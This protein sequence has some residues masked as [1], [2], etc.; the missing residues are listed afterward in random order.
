MFVAS[1]YISISDI[2]M[3]TFKFLSMLGVLVLSF[4]LAWSAVVVVALRT[5][6]EHRIVNVRKIP[7]VDKKWENFSSAFVS[8]V[9]KVAA[10]EQKP[11]VMFAGSSVTYGYPWQERI[12]YTKVVANDLPEWKVSN[13]S[14][15]G[16]GMQSLTDFATCAL[17]SENRPSILIV[18]IPLVNSTASISPGSVRV[19]RRCLPYD[20]GFPGYWSLV[21]SKPYG[22]G[23]VSILWDEEAYEKPDAD[24]VITPLPPTYFA[25][26]Q[27]FQK[28][29]DYYVSELRRFISSVSVM[30]GKVFVYV[31]PILA[32]AISKAGGDRAAVEY[33]IELTNK[34]CLEY[35]NVTCLDSSI[36]SDRP[37]LFYNLTHLNHRGHRALAQWFE[38]YI[39]SQGGSVVP[40]RR[41][42][43]TN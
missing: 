25:D 8:E 14:I 28:I 30:S 37:E 27:H 1:S 31:S 40:P 6:Y 32:T 38:P 22:L 41:P 39:V 20:Q 29:E 10:T 7:N 43:L 4:H 23:W 36:F 34:I 9:I 17:S 19:P 5:F 42:P 18:E 13:L 2:E 33:Q 21:A 24:L 11:H 15:I 3:T 16:V 12:I 26:K 35:K